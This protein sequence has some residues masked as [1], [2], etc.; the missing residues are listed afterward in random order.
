MQDELP[1]DVLLDMLVFE[2]LET[3]N[4]KLAPYHL[5]ARWVD[6]NRGEVEIVSAFGGRVYSIGPATAPKQ[7][8]MFAEQDSGLEEAAAAITTA[9][10][11]SEQEEPRPR[12]PLGEVTPRYQSAYRGAV[13]EGETDWD[14]KK[15]EERFRSLLLDPTSV[16]NALIRFYANSGISQQRHVE[17]PKKVES[18]SDARTVNN[19]MRHAYRVLNDDEKA[20]MQNIKDL[21]LEFI[22][23]LDT[24]EGSR[25][26]SIAK[27]KIEE[28]VMWACKSIT[29]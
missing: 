23:L 12:P 15:L 20:A 7:R 10:E 29:K 14:A 11:D 13:K 3:A 21:G 4:E 5:T 24:L 9:M 22:E 1:L 17:E 2:D 16:L 18:T 27:T 8:D 6:A 19:T 26:I 28:A 25:E